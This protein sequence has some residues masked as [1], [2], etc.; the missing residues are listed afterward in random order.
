M[1]NKESLR[2]TSHRVKC[3][4]IVLLGIYL[5]CPEGDNLTY[6]TYL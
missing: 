4:I 6:R 3:I 5:I 2:I 1:K